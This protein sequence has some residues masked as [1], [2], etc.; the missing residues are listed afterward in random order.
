MTAPD[1]DQVDQVDDPDAC[2][3]CHGTGEF[4]CSRGCHVCE[5]PDCEGTGDK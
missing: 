3:A 4:E 2:L 1:V 5:C